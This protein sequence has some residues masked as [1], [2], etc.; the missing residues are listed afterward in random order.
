MRLHR[1]A[2]RTSARLLLTLLATALAA[3][4]AARPHAQ[5]QTSST[6]RQFKSV[7]IAAIGRANAVA[8]IASMP[9]LSPAAG[10]WLFLGPCSIANGQGLSASGECGPPARITVTGRVTAIGFGAEGIYV[11]SASGGVWKS[12][13]GGASWAP[14]TDQQPSLAVGA[15]AVLPGPPDTIY[16]GTVEGN[17]GCDNLYGQ[18][19]LMS[20]DGG[21]TWTQLGAATFDGLT[22]TRLAVTPGNPNVIYAATSFGYTNGGAGEC[23]PVSNA[24]AGLYK[25]G[26][27]GQ[28]WTFLSG[29]GGLR[30]GA[31]GATADGSGSVYDVLIDPARSFSGAFTGAV[32]AGNGGG[33]AGTATLTAIDPAN[34]KNPNPFK[35]I[36]APVASGGFSLS[37]TLTLTQSPM[38]GLNPPGI[39]DDF[40][41]TYTCSGTVANL[42]GAPVSDL[43]CAGGNFNGGAG[44]TLTL[45]GSFTGGE[46]DSGGFSGN[47]S[48][49][50]GAGPDTVKQAPIALTS[51]PTVFAAMGGANGGVFRTTDAGM[52][53]TSESAIAAARRFAMGAA[54]DGSRLYVASTALTNPPSFGALYISTDHGDT[55]MIETGQPNIGGAGCLT[56]NQGDQDLALAVDPASPD[57]MYLGMVGIYVSS[58]GGASFSY[59]GAG[60]HGGQHAIGINAGNVYAGNNGGLF[61]SADGGATWS[62]LNSGLGIV[63][64]QDVAVSPNG[65]TVL[66]GMQDNGTNQTSGGL[67]WSHSDDG[68]S[69]FVA[70]DSLNPATSFDE[71]TGLSLNRSTSS[72]ALGSYSPIIPGAAATD[73]LQ[74]YA[75]FT[76]DPSNPDRILFGTIR[77]WESCHASGGQMV[78]DGASSPSPPMWTVLSA[79]LTGGCTTRCATSAISRWRPPIPT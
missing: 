30:P 39:C 18:G 49:E 37:A 8:A 78:C 21:M 77:L 27:G 22:F 33:C 54:L 58:D 4:L 7:R 46:T 5:T 23:F 52:T 74:L 19:V 55:F 61:Q 51:A 60:V 42:D 34:A 62:A 10:Q 48:L 73:P 76:L 68:S 25:S 38:A 45:N 11:G 1:P 29:S 63:Q 47:W 20:S 17:N 57:H 50:A 43:T 70:I 79:D 40:S 72:A 9:A 31:A 6:N 69:G 65:T 24:T 32:T 14:L 66:G 16:V 75:P 44:T 71:Q 59:T 35:L 12:T 36:A 3:V 53:W 15:L 41:G 2:A 56:E 64:L 28:T 67:T 13:D 26:D